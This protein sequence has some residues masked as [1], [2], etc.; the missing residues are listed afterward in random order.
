MFTNSLRTYLYQYSHRQSK[1]LIMISNCRIRLM[2]YEKHGT[3]IKFEHIQIRSYYP[4]DHGCYTPGLYGFRDYAVHVTTE[5]IQACTEQIRKKNEIAWCS[6][7]HD[8]C[9]TIIQENRL[10]IPTDP[11]GM[12]ELYK[13]LRTSIRNDL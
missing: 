3:I 11:D 10:P 2:T 9:H 13:F 8:L 7:I 6:I 12:C 4:A 1:T 5:D